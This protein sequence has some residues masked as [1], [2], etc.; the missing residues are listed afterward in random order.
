[1]ATPDVRGQAIHMREHVAYA[2]GA[3]VSKTLLDKKSGTLTLF[4]FDKGQGLSEH[5]SPYDATVLIVDG[6][7]TLVIGGKP[8]TAKSGELVIMP[9][10]VPHELRADEPFKMLLIMIRE[11]SA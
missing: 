1:M 9:A 7:A 5:T 3:V 6:Q 10:G 4:S 11:Q 8:V 2:D